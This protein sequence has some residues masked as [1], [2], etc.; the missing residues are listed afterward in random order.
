MWQAGR[1]PGAPLADRFDGWLVDLDGVV[2]VGD[3]A[4]PG[5]AEAI[6]ELRSRRHAVTF[7]TNDPRSSRAAYADKLTRLGIPTAPEDVVTS[8]SAT[9][10]VVASAGLAGSTVFVVGSE[11]LKEEMRRVGC[12]VLED[13]AG[14]DA[15]LVVVGG[16][17]GFDYRELAIGSLAVRRGGKL[18]ATNRDATFPTPDGPA[19]ATGAIV[20]AVEVGS[21][22]V[23]T[24]VGKPEPYMFEQAR[25]RM[26]ADARVAVVGDRLDSDILGGHRAGLATV[27]LRD[28]TRP[29]A[30]PGRADVEPDHVVDSLAGLLDGSSD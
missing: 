30:D 1:M 14:L 4:L 9:A 24:A 20:A 7:V 13:R 15:D 19:P 17:E 16:H 25:A 28:P 27:L 23:A 2:Y 8:A 29:D 11:A 22:T 21:G 12:R 26:P 5:S 18:Y 3:Q 10:D 6:A